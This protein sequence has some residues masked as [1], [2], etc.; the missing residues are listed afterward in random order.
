MMPASPDLASVL[1]S[2]GHAKVEGHAKKGEAV[3]STPWSPELRRDFEESARE[4]RLYAAR[5][6]VLDGRNFGKWE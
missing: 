3:A 4:M 1:S 6:E 2:V 5:L